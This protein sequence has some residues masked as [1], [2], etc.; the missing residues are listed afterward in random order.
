MFNRRILG[1][2]FMALSIA[3]CALAG[4]ASSVHATEKYPSRTV[5]IVIALGPGSATDTFARLLADALSI[6]SPALQAPLLVL[7]SPNPR[8]TATRWACSIRRY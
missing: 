2:S 7:R 5:K 8:P 1:K 4:A 6:T 3:I